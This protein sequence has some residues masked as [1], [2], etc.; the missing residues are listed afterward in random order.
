MCRVIRSENESDLM[1]DAI[2]T[3]PIYNSSKTIMN[4]L[5]KNVEKEE[6]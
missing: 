5:K 6:L 2:Q 1:W 4:G 3:I